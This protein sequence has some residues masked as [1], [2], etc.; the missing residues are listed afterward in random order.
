MP[1]VYP[2]DVISHHRAFIA[3]RRA[4]RPSE[5]YREL[6]ADEWEQFLGHFELR[7]F[8]GLRGGG[9]GDGQASLVD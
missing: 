7:K 9:R 2:E 5:E 4:L 6:T 3:R 1:P 8:S